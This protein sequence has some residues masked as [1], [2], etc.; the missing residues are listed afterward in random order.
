MEDDKK[1]KRNKKK[2]NKQTKTTAEDDSAVGLDQNGM[3]N[4]KN[5]CDQANLDNVQNGSLGN[6]D[7]GPDRHQNNGTDISILTEAEKQQWLQREA[8]LKQ[9]IK[10]LQNENDSH[11]QKEAIIEE[12]IKQLQKEND[13][14]RQQT[15]TLE[16]KLEH[17]KNV[18]DSALQKEFTLKEKIQLLKNENDSHLQKEAGLE[19][20]ILQLQ[21]E[22]RIILQTEAS[23]EEKIKQ[24]ESN[25]VSWT[26]AEVVELEES[27]NS[28]LIENQQLVENISGLQL[29][30]QSLE[31]D[32]S[33]KASDELKKHASEREELNSQ[34]E[35]ACVLVDKLITENADLVEKVNELYVK[36]DRQSSPAGLSSTTGHE[37]MVEN[38][39]NVIVT[40]SIAEPGENITAVGLKFET[41]EVD[42]AAVVTYDAEPDSGEIVQIPLDDNELRDLEMQAVESDKMEAIPLS[43]APLIGAP[44]R[45]ISFFT[46]YV[47]G[48]DLV[49]KNTLNSR[50]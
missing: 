48:A 50:S 16:R 3:S 17:L 18:N 15:A 45:L 42:R 13:S 49:E 25:K 20:K 44:F 11:M 1:K 43:D 27:R 36:L 30:L 14:H 29:Q 46:S 47:S 4:G 6:A 41:L 8:I 34:I 37:L 12:K 32:I 26:L 5:D 9:T 31:T 19:T 33:A 35:A 22:K 24:L 21:D 10:Q 28:L 40:N 38:A 39:E 2:K 7:V 23:L